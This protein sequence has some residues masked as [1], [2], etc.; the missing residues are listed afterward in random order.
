MRAAGAAEILLGMVFPDNFCRAEAIGVLSSKRHSGGTS[1][2]KF[3]GGKT[4][5]LHDYSRTADKPDP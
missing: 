1:P 2:L 3:S 5:L 4:H